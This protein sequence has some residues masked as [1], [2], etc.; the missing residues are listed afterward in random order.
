MTNANTT[1]TTETITTEETT[2]GPIGKFFGKMKA[3][4]FITI[5]AVGS[6]AGAGFLAYTKLYVNGDPIGAAQDAAGAIA[7]LA[8]LGR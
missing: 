7:S 4:P 6:A 8:A 5:G 1:S 2:V 3:H